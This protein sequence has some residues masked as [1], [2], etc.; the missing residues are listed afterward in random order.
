MQKVDPAFL[1][2]SGDAARSFRRIFEGQER[3]DVWLALNSGVTAVNTC[4][5]QSIYR[6]HFHAP[7]IHAARK[8]IELA[9][10]YQGKLYPKE[11]DGQDLAAWEINVLNSAYTKFETILISELQSISSYIV[12]KKGGFDTEA[13]VDAGK[14]FFSKDLEAKVPT[15]IPDLEQAMRCIAF[16]VPTA[17][18][19]H[20]HRANESV[21]RAYWDHV[22]NGVKRPK[23]NNMGVYLR[24]LERLDKGNKSVRAHLQSIKDFHRNPL[25]HPEQSLETVEEAIDLMAAIRCAIGYML[26]EI[27]VPVSPLAAALLDGIPASAPVG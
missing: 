26:K 13:M 11:G 5:Y 2:E 16:E 25:M 9:E 22:T 4:V 7:L 6:E 8:L 24:E 17:A 15:A 19:F 1:F 21:L 27:P 23:E 20:L 14:L 3:I 18:G 12:T 10:G